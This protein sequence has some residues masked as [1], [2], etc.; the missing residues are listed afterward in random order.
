MGRE[1]GLR[2]VPVEVDGLFGGGYGLGFPLG[3]VEV[4]REV[5]QRL[6][7]LCGVCA[8]VDLRQVT[9][10][11]DDLLGGVQALVLIAGLAQAHG[12]KI[13]GRGEI[14]SVG[15][16]GPR[17][18]T[19]DTDGVTRGSDSLLRSAGVRQAGTEIQLLGGVVVPGSVLWVG[20]GH[21]TVLSERGRVRSRV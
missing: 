8:R 21:T 10:D 12:E 17:Q 11:A 4:D 18:V 3:R 15:A 19:Q 1:V 13:Q 9:S 7:E 20:D 14:G 6:G 16:V 5:V 2:Q